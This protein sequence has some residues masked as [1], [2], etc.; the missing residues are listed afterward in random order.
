M[1]F[2]DKLRCVK[3]KIGGDVST[4]YF[5]IIEDQMLQIKTAFQQ[6]L[7]F[8]LFPGTFLS[9]VNIY[10]GLANKFVIIF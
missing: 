8:F 4:F 9:L 10:R 7:Y 5:I 1:I 6:I 3:Y 2:I